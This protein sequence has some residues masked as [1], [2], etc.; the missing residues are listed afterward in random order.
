MI[1]DLDGCL[2]SARVRLLDDLLEDLR[3]FLA[4]VRVVYSI[5][6]LTVDLDFVDD[7]EGDEEGDER[8]VQVEWH[9]LQR[10]LDQVPDGLLVDGEQVVV[11]LAELE[12]L[13]GRVA[14]GYNE[15]GLEDELEE[16][17]SLRVEVALALPEIGR[18][19]RDSLSAEPRHDFVEE[20]L[21]SV[22]H[23]Q[24]EHNL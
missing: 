11:R 9:A 17:P 10:L 16:L 2:L 6:V 13:L 22:D 18:E 12:H 15:A 7:V 21:L 19:W 4:S 24:A 5:A 20:K 23:S 14:V 8:V 1:L 3:E